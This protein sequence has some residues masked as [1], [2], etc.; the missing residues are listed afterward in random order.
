MI[1]K[2]K[3]RIWCACLLSLGLG[4]L[5]PVSAPAESWKRVI[6]KCAPEDLDKVRAVIGGA[7]L[8][9][10]H[11]YFVLNVPA[12]VDIKKVES[13]R[14]R[15]PIEADDDEDVVLQRRPARSSA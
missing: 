6:I 9:A 2:S 3:I 11:G 5:A 13:I 8:D 12:S 10:G 15:A 7:I 14:G 1:S 4:A